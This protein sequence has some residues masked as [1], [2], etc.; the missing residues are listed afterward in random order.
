M[1]QQMTCDNWSLLPPP[2]VSSELL[3]LADGCELLACIL[4]QRGYDT[5]AK[6]QPF[7]DAGMYRPSPPSALYGMDTAAGLLVRAIQQENSILIWGDFDVDGQTS[8]ALLVDALHKTIGPD[9]VRYHIP[10]RFREGHGI[11]LDV[12]K[13]I[14]SQP[15]FS[16]S[17]L[18]TC[19]TGIAEGPAIGYA[20]DQQLTVIITDHH[21]LT[22]EFQNVQPE[23]ETVSGLSSLAVGHDSARRADAIVNPKLQPPEDAQG[24]LPGVGVAYKLIQEVYSRIGYSGAET[25]YLDL[26]ALGIV[27]DVAEQVRDTRYFLQRGIEQ[28][29][30]TQRTGLLALMDVARVTA[31]SVDTQAIGYQLSPRLNALGRLDD[32]TVAVEL[33]T[34]KDPVRAQQLAS[35]TERLNQ[36]R[37]LLTSQIADAAMEML[38]RSPHLLEFSALV[39]SHP[40]WHAGIVGIVAAR[41]AEEFNRPAV[42]LLTPPGELARGSVRS[43]PGIDIGASIAACGN[44]LVGHGGHPGAAGLR[45]LPENIDRFRRELDRQV[46]L[47]RTPDVVPGL[48]VDA[49]LPLNELDIPLAQEMQRLAPFGNGN[50]TPLFISERL[51]VTQ[52]RRIGRDGAHR[53]LAVANAN[54]SPLPVI[55]FG[56]G[57]LELPSAPIDLVYEMGTHEY[58]GKVELQLLYVNSRS[59]PPQ[60]ADSPDDIHQPYH[61]FDLRMTV[62]GV[63]ELPSPEQAVWYAE[64]TNLES[65]TEQVPYA[66]R[67]DIQP[68]VQSEHLVIWSIPPSPRLLHW[69]IDT[70]KPHT[71]HLCGRHT[72][73]D[74]LSS[75]LRQ[76][77]GMGKFALSR[78]LPLNLTHMAAR[79]GT[80]EAAIRLSLLLLESRGTLEVH[81]WLDDDRV[82]IRAGRATTDSTQTYALQAALT[83]HLAEVRAYRRFFT[84]A[85]AGELGLTA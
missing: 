34:T 76:V 64:G 81:S 84:G 83:E 72:A 80:T 27:A 47:H 45:L 57:D 31:S 56:G 53:R 58:R 65:T 5:P 59:S 66:P 32:A 14:L 46:Q 8:T 55:W 42:L 38:D 50:P 70:V 4:A 62:P 30:V 69:L 48:I 24:T 3:A 67:Q 15:D 10:N 39:L 60:S 36:Q 52:D 11:D 54:S 6:A 82:E 43:V 41:L 21:D 23:S 13:E 28:L 25:E 74:S 19:D 51:D 85:S 63:Q 7:L 79:L 29:R 12:L 78:G 44:L 71:V 16:P 18:L 68:G 9:R 33:L 61:L 22:P 49:M 73:D 26:V 1:A 37:R 77:A 17:L 75:V 35:R 40:A 20:K 2:T